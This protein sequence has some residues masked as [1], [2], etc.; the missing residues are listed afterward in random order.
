[1]PLFDAAQRAFDRAGH[2]TTED[3][4]KLFIDGAH[5]DLTTSGVLTGQAASIC[6][7]ND[8]TLPPILVRLGV[9]VLSITELR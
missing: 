6:A 1:M 9:E 2:D 7:V 4:P 3:R 8:K 5:I